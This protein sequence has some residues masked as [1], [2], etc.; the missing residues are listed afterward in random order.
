MTLP[1]P[2][3]TVMPYQ[4]SNHPSTNPNQL[5]RFASFVFAIKSPYT[6]A[7]NVLVVSVAHM[8]RRVTITVMTFLEMYA[9]GRII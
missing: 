4:I 7:I 8:S 1:T 5:E 3:P 2:T 9:F 6:V